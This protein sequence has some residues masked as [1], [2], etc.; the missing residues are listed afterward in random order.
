MRRGNNSIFAT[1]KIICNETKDYC[2][3]YTG[4]SAC[5][6]SRVA[7]SGKL[8]RGAAPRSLLAEVAGTE[9]RSLLFWQP[10]RQGR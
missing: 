2:T 1:N 3:P 5:S 4:F 9:F 7:V 10:T 8:Q 6:G